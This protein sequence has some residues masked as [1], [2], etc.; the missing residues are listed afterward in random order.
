MTG[1]A[2]IAGIGVA[3]VPAYA[4]SF[5]QSWNDNASYRASKDFIPT[6]TT[7]IGGMA[8]GGDEATSFNVELVKTSNK[9]VVLTSNLRSANNTWYWIGSATI[10]ANNAYYLRWYGR[11]LNST[12]GNIDYNKIAP[13][14]GVQAK[15]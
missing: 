14:Q 13:C 15:W 9:A 2:A 10:Q 1:T 3:A 5:S 4:G 6:T 11:A 7:T 8:C 12:T